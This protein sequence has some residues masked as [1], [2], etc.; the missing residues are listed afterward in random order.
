MGEK[1]KGLTQD[2]NIRQG[3]QH[4]KHLEAKVRVVILFF[5]ETLTSSYMQTAITG[6]FHL[7]QFLVP[8]A[9]V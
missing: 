9:H 8:R 5:Q 6:R 4:L 3:T 1:A 7:T 2:V